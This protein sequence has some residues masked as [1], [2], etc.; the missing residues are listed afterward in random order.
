MPGKKEWGR[1][2]A[3]CLVGHVRINLFYT[4]ATASLSLSL[5]LFFFSLR[6]LLCFASPTLFFPLGLALAHKFDR[7]R[8]Q[9]VDVQGTAP[10]KNAHIHTGLWEKRGSSAQRHATYAKRFVR[11]TRE[12]KSQHP[13]IQ[14]TPTHIRT[15]RP[16]CRSS[17]RKQKRILV[18]E[19]KKKRGSRNR[20]PGGGFRSPFADSVGPF[21]CSCARK[22]H[23]FEGRHAP[24]HT[25]THT[26]VYASTRARLYAYRGSEKNGNAYCASFADHNHAT[27]HGLST[28]GAPRQSPDGRRRRPF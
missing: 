16:W 27:R 1:P 4:C 22:R 6:A 12:K 21:S 23:S 13:R 2:E 3:S 20:E 25:H 5:F 10:E 26:Q 19:K 15:S 24:L 14:I 7:G 17:K 9:P 18:R 11:Q 28:T 8:I